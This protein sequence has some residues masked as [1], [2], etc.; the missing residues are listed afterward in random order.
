MFVIAGSK[1]Y[2]A[3]NQSASELKRTEIYFNFSIFTVNSATMA[4]H[5]RNLTKIRIQKKQLILFNIIRIN[6]LNINF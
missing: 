6:C 3:T 4:I 1:I 2:C 5:A